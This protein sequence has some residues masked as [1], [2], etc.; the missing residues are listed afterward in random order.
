MRMESD[1]MK[2]RA[3]LKRTI[4]IAAPL[5]LLGGGTDFYAYE[6]EPAWIEITT[7]VVKLPRLDPAFQNYRLVQ[8]SDIHADDTWMTAERVADIVKQVNEQKPNMI[9]ITGDFVTTLLPSSP[10]SLAPL[11]DLQ[12][13]DGV[14]AVLGNHD[15]WTNVRKIRQLLRANGIQE[16]KNDIHTINR[17]N[18]AMLHMVGLDDLWPNHSDIP[19]PSSIWQYEGK[20][21]SLTETLPETGAA[22]LLVHEPD[23]ADVAAANG[24]IDLEL[25]G[26]SHGGQVRLPFYGAV[27]LP[28]LA[29]NYPS[30]M[31]QIGKLQHYTNRGLGMVRPQV[32]FDCRPEITVFIC[33]T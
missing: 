23:F 25:S 19:S 1:Q 14:F 9:V 5:V 22:I 21:K 32:R 3:F 2:R 26:H 27:D 12:A 13:R 15:H 18:N 6:I 33:Q 4:A 29:K 20:L 31:Y 24:R 17:S 10:R 7:R 8:I 28:P 11:Q 30:G 16:L